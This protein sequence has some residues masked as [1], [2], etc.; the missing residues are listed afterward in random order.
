MIEYT[1]KIREIAA[2]LLKEGKVNMVI[3]F[4][5][6]TVPMMNELK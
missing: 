3:G 1:Q 2:R 4:R 5:K 6:G